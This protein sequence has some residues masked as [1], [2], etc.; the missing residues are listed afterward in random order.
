MYV[1]RK[2][3][4]YIT[5]I[6]LGVGALGVVLMLLLG[7]GM[8]GSDDGFGAVF[9]MVFIVLAVIGIIGIGLIVV[10]MMFYQKS[11]VV[12]LILLFIFGL[13]SLNLASGDTP[14]FYIATGLTI[15]PLVTIIGY[16]FKKNLDEEP[17]SEQNT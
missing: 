12:P 5:S 11:I 6:S 10:L 16:F 17:N 4:F 9:G 8:G 2:V 14:I 3:G 1:L 15:G 13:T 7:V